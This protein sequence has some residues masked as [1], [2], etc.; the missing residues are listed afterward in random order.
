[1]TC[2]QP[3]AFVL[4]QNRW[5]CNHHFKSVLGCSSHNTQRKEKSP[6]YLSSYHQNL[7]NG[8]Y[9][10]AKEVRS[11]R[12]GLN[13]DVIVKRYNEWRGKR[14]PDLK[15]AMEPTT[16]RN[17][18]GSSTTRNFYKEYSNLEFNEDRTPKQIKRWNRLKKSIINTEE[19]LY[20]I[21]PFLLKEDSIVFKKL[22]HV[23]ERDSSYYKSDEDKLMDK[24]TRKRAKNWLRHTKKCKKFKKQLP[25]LPPDFNGDVR[26]F[27]YQT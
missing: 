27:Y 5:K 23:V 19:H 6:Q 4:P 10:F 11:T 7:T 12:L 21:K 8:S 13:Y 18:N 9:N 2:N 15:D 26:T 24:L 1:N 16:T 22:S 3:A 14:D 20:K 17:K 25:D